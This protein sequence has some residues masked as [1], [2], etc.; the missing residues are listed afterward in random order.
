MAIKHKKKAR[1]TPQEI[2]A[3]IQNDVDTVIQI[4]KSNNVDKKYTETILKLKDCRPNIWI[5]PKNNR[6]ERKQRSWINPNNNQIEHQPKYY[7]GK[8]ICPVCSFIKN[9][10]EVKKFY[11]T[12]ETLKAKPE[13]KNAK[14]WLLTLKL[15]PHHLLDT[16]DKV[17][18]INKAFSKFLR[19]TQP[20]NSTQKK[21]KMKGKSFINLDVEYS[22]F[23]H[24]GFNN[25][26]E[27]AT[28]HL[29]VVL[30]TKENFR[31]DNRITESMIIERWKKA[32]GSPDCYIH[33]VPITDTKQDAV[34]T[35]AYGL[36]TLKI[37]SAKKHPKK[38]LQLVDQLERK[39]KF[40][41]AKGIRE[42]RAESNR[43]HKQSIKNKKSSN[44]SK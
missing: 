32:T 36:K 12:Y 24:V 29:H 14:L 34:D 21:K 31:A 23:M 27:F 15:P 18:F 16:R 42:I 5:N 7:C 8:S 25:C 44:N 20:K 28:V 4:L 22:K 41:H 10:I 11:E 39:H 1:K 43:K 6:I 33:Y 9:R 30:F 2:F 19:Y 17:E 3:E 26:K 35:M 13:F 37:E 38:F 40:S